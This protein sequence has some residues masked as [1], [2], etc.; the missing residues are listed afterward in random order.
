MCEYVTAGNVELIPSK[1]RDTAFNYYILYHYVI[2]LE[3]QTTK[4]RVVFNVFARTM[5]R[6]V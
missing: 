6:Y 4:L 1:D 2:Q 3:S 5:D